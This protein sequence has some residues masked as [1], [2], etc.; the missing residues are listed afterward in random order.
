MSGAHGDD[1]NNAE[2]SMAVRCLELLAIYKD[3]SE[4]EVIKRDTI[5][6]GK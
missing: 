4:K 1:A 2:I 3:N 6:D 5:I